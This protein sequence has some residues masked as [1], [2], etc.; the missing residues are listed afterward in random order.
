[1][2][3]PLYGSIR[4]CRRQFLGLTYCESFSRVARRQMSSLTMEPV[5][6]EG[7][8]REQALPRINALLDQGQWKLDEERMGLLKTYYFKTYTKCL[9]F[10]QVIGIRSKSKNHHSTMTI[11]AGSVQV[12]WTTH[13][14]R[15]LSE[16]DIQMAQYCDEQAR[17][18]GTVDPAES[19]RCGPEKKQSSS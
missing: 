19:N 11:K 2:A 15:G 4:L 14:P 16:K 1:M 8:D 5:F 12:H 9:D 6:A 7:V 3:S 17:L 10:S 18:I 13:F